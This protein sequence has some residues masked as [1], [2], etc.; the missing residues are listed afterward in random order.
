MFV[1]VTIG[2]QASATIAGPPA[3]L[4]A[5]IRT[6]RP[7]SLAEDDSEVVVCGRR[8]AADR[9]RLRSLPA[10]ASDGGLPKAEARIFGN[11]KLSAE[12]E[13]ASVGGFIS[14]RAMVRLKVPF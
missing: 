1:L 14:N 9:Y 10:T 13:A 11:A 4:P 7:C 2:M 3:P 8:H 5:P 12:A 6:I